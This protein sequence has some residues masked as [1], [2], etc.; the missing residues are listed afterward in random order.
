MYSDMEDSKQ[1]A[2]GL[3]ELSKEIRPPK[4]SNKQEQDKISNL[5]D[6]YERQAR[7]LQEQI[8]ALKEKNQDLKEYSSRLEVELVNAKVAL[9]NQ[10]DEFC[11]LELKYQKITNEKVQRSSNLFR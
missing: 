4:A 7:G 2:E 3:A 10:T 5:V 11:E 8:R 9:C 1:D 6:K